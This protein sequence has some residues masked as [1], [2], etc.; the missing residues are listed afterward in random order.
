VR[1]ALV[2]T[3][4]LALLLTGCVSVSASDET[5]CDSL[6]R[7]RDAAFED[8]RE[9]LDRLLGELGDAASDASISGV[10]RPYL[11]DVVDDAEREARGRDVK[12]FAGHV[13]DALSVC[14]D[15]GW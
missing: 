11:E 3:G 8:D 14:M 10:L 7:N 15:V 13:N 6:H 4:A 12:L 1:R 5:A 2:G 9:A